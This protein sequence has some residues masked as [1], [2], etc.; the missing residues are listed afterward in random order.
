MP[1]YPELF[2]TQLSTQ[3]DSPI[4]LVNRAISGW[5]VSRGLEDLGKLLASHPDLVIV[6][7]GM[8]HF[9]G[10]DPE[11][12]RKLLA[13]MLDRIRKAEPEAEVLLVA[14]MWG[15][16]MWSPRRPIN[17]SLIATPSRRWSAQG[18]PWPT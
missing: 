6:A 1:A 11:G 13:T 3:F 17:I 14:P 5:G 7:Y 16:P 9:G 12:F 4:A 15:N 18:S 10:R 8:N 2:V